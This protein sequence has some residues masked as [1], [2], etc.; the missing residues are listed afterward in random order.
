M[1]KNKKYL[2]M[3]SPSWPSAVTASLIASAI[4]LGTVIIVRGQNSALFDGFFAT[5]NASISSYKILTTSLA[6]NQIINNAPLFIFWLAVGTIVYLLAVKI[7]GVVS[8]TEELREEMDY[9]NVD[10]L[11]LIRSAV[12][13]SFVRLVGAGLWLAYLL[14]FFKTAVPFLL[15]MTRTAALSARPVDILYIGAFLIVMALSL[16]VN[17]VFLRIVLLRTRIFI[18]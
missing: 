10:R 16:Y 11:S 6:K 17:V 4:I 8:R 1:Q 2:A 13:E 3:L 18:N 12:I 7:Y 5:Q 9:V 15:S 14:L